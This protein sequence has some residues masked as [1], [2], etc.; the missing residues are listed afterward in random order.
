MVYIIGIIVAIIIIWCIK[1]LIA[2]YWP[3]LLL[4]FGTILIFVFMGPSGGI[5]AILLFVLVG[6]IIEQ[7]KK[8]NE[9]KLLEF[10]K[11]NCTQLGFV[12]S[13]DYDKLAPNFKDKSYKTSYFQ[14]VSSFVKQNEIQYID[15]NGHLIDPAVK[16]INKKVMADLL[17]LMVLNYPGLAYTHC[18]PNEEIIVNRLAQKCGKDK[19]ITNIKLQEDKVKEELARKKVPYS[20]YYLNAYKVNGSELLSSDNFESE[21]ISL[22]DL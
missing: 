1:E 7:C 15:N 13:S 5:F 8:V 20:D 11:L 16:Y 14:I 10:L 3:I 17:E 22:D 12:S 2:D 21:E 18:T 9:K 19:K 6:F 4:I